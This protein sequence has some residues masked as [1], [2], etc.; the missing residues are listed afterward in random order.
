MVRCEFD[1]HLLRADGGLIGEAP[2]EQKSVITHRQCFTRQESSATA[3][4]PACYYPVSCDQHP[5]GRQ[6]AGIVADVHVSTKCVPRW[7]RAATQS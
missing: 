1:V 7:S 6:S 2:Y 5:L 3:A 4:N